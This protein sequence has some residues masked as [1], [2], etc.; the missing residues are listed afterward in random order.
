MTARGP[1]KELE[2]QAASMQS[3]QEPARINYLHVAQTLASPESWRGSPQRFVD[4][5]PLLILLNVYG[6]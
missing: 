4:L 2:D 6:T 3:G 1:S 5:W